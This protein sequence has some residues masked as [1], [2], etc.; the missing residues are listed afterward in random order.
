MSP[1]ILSDHSKNHNH[2][3]VFVYASYK[4][5]LLPSTLR[6]LRHRSS[7]D[8]ILK[9]FLDSAYQALR[10]EALV[11]A[12][13]TGNN[14]VALP[15]TFQELADA[16][17]VTS[18]WPWAIS[19][20]TL[21]Q[22][23]VVLATRADFKDAMRG[24][25]AA[26]W[27][28]E[29][30][31]T[32]EL[33]LTT[34]VTSELELISKA[35]ETIKL[36]AWIDFFLYT[37]HSNSDIVGKQRVIVRVGSDEVPSIEKK[38]REDRTPFHAT[39]CG[40]ATAISDAV[41]LAD[42]RLAGDGDQNHSVVAVERS[43]IPVFSEME[44]G[45]F[46]TKLEQRLKERRIKV[47]ITSEP[48]LHSQPTRAA[49]VH[50]DLGRLL[51]EPD[52]GRSEKHFQGTLELLHD[53]IAGSRIYAP[54]IQVLLLGGAMNDTCAVAAIQA[55]DSLEQPYDPV[56]L[57]HLL[58][59]KDGHRYGDEPVNLSKVQGSPCQQVAI[60]GM[61]CR[62]PGANDAD[63][64]WQLLMEGKSTCEE[65]PDRLYRY[66]DYHA[67]SY[68][69]RNVMRVKTGNFIASSGLFDKGI[70]G[71][72][73]SSEDC[74]KIDPQQRLAILTAHETLQ[75]AGYGFSPFKHPRCPEQWSTHIAYCSDDY[76][77]HLSQNIEADFVSN[78]HRAHLVAKI[79]ENFGFRG[80]ACT[81]DTACSSALVAVEAA[82]N[83]LLAGETSAAL[84]GG[85]N[86]LTQPQITIG[87]DR[88]FF[89]SPSS[90]CMTLD[91]AG[92]GYSRAD[93]VSIMLLK[94]L[95]DAVRDG[96]PILA[97][98]SSAATNHSGESFSITHP[99][100]RTQ[101]RLYQAGMLA[102]GTLPKDF[103]YIEMHGTGTQSG[104]FEEVTGIVQTFAE[105]KRGKE[106]PLVLGSLKANI[107]HSEAASGASSMI[108][109]IQIYAHG[110]VPRH[111]GIRT[112][113]NTKLPPLDGLHVPLQE[114]KLDRSEFAF[115]LVDNFS[116]AGG[117][118]SI[119]MNRGTVY[120]ER[121]SKM[122]IAALEAD[123]AQD[124]ASSTKHHLLFV[125]AATPFSLDAKR[126]RLISFL[127]SNTDVSL[128]EFCST[129][130]LSD[131]MHSFRLIASPSSLAEARAC[132]SSQ[133]SVSVSFDSIVNKKPTIGIAFSGQGAQY[134][135]MAREL[136][137]RSATFRSHVDHCNTIA[138]SLQLPNLVEVIHPLK[139]P[140]DSSQSKIEQP[141]ERRADGFSPA[142]YQ[143]ALIATE[144]GLASMLRGWGLWPACVV[145]HSLGEYAALWMSGIISLLSL[146]ELVGRRAML[147]MELCEPNASSMLA[148][149]EGP[150]RVRQLL[151]LPGYE[152]L[153]IACLNSPNDTVVAGGT[154]EIESLLQLCEQ[155]KPKVKAMAIPVPYA[156]HSRAVE[157][158]MK[159]FAMVADCHPF[160]RPNISVASNV[161]GR[162]PNS[163]SDSFNAAYLVRHLRQ[164]V[165]FAESILDL[166]SQ[167]RVDTWIEI[168]P[169]P[170]CIPMLKGCYADSGQT[171]AFVA[172]FRKGSSS[173]TCTLNLVKEL[174]SC[175]IE[176][177]WSHVFEDL[178]LRFCHLGL[179][180][181][182]PLYP[183]DLEEYW[184]PFKD[185]CL[186]DHLMMTQ[187]DQGCAPARSANAASD[188]HK[189]VVAVQRWP[190]PSYAL[191]WQCVKLDGKSPSAMFLARVN[192]RPFRDFIQG[193][194]ILGIPLAPAT[195]FIE[196]AQEAGMYWWRTDPCGIK[197][198]NQQ[199]DDV[200]IEVLDLSMV[201][202]LY[203]N[204][205]DPKQ[206]IEVSLQGNPASTDGSIVQFFS[207]N[208]NQ[209][210]KH[211]YGS[212]RVRIIT[213]AQVTRD[214]AKISH[215]IMTTASTVKANAASVI[216]TDTVYKNFEAIV[217]YLD[218]FRG[219]KTVW[220]TEDGYEAV[221][222]VSF[223]ANAVNGR[224][225]CSPML[226]DSLGGLTGFISNVGFAEGPF[227]FMAEAIGRVVTM[228]GL[229][230]LQPGSD[231]KVHVYARM[232]RDKELSKGSA[233]FFLPDGELM[234]MMAS[235]I[236]KRIR[237][238]ML[239]RLVQISSKAFASEAAEAARERD[240]KVNRT[241]DTKS[242]Q[243]TSERRVQCQ[244]KNGLLKEAKASAAPLHGVTA[245]CEPHCDSPMDVLT[246]PNKRFSCSAPLHICGPQL[247]Q[248]DGQN[249][250]F[251]FP[252]GSGTASIYPKVEST[253]SV[254][255]YGFH[256]PYLGQIEA[257]SR[258]IA[259]LVDRYVE[260]LHEV[261]PRGPY[262]LAG[263]S[264]GGVFA[265]EVARRLLS[266]GHEVNYLGLIDSPNPAQIRPLPSNTLDEILKKITS[267]T[268]REHFKSCAL[269]LPEYRCSAFQATDRKPRTVF[270]ANA[271]GNSKLKGVMANEREW[272]C[273][274]STTA[275]LELHEV[276]GD[277]WTCLE[278]AL[279]LV[280]NS[281]ARVKP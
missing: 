37:G 57:L 65:I 14:Q 242:Q 120:R 127:D 29:S 270:I 238:D 20:T 85:V 212:C 108:K 215:L 218:G 184:V 100:G 116:A 267:N 156:F 21:V 266:V 259:E 154:A 149:R 237:R 163:E 39:L 61:S 96:D 277:H 246:N 19:L 191:L 24:N 99:H 97:V 46:R 110:E 111:I 136:Y 216:R 199:E 113:L 50:V 80:E 134:L 128:T 81:Y 62:L 124:L 165:Q 18:A 144:V 224:F 13:I 185:R 49:D 169:H 181:R 189:G 157:P 141:H 59:P 269:S 214:W 133:E 117:N 208:A 226:L 76:R 75:K 167:I 27:D 229:R 25:F 41:N 278:S 78:T 151:E 90:Q 87:L 211:Q 201:A 102:S 146:I 73:V 179:A 34:R 153:E 203:L 106:S 94:R 54:R 196:L 221:S 255:V 162:V 135:D 60:I 207:H 228:P 77:E 220:M 145:G 51:L 98:I 147:M 231:T 72:A 262:M 26:I 217:L 35:V 150:E 265:L 130:S 38:C 219:M 275:N 210:Q 84:T 260:M 173:W 17:L 48:P 91:D 273:F 249:V 187:G 158:L 31:L 138:L 175:G 280:V 254:S 3:V 253:G 264:I 6:L 190:K 281:A 83:S 119:V 174:A 188:A 194:I 1:G 223:N 71:E 15:H 68:R 112:K 74:A 4:Q 95:Q 107:G 5:I 172:S 22:V 271:T 244:S 122:S 235:I 180:P 11:A 205:Q 182:L 241:D 129:V 43:L 245:T 200:I 33:L 234:G 274:W 276:N 67:A 258:G 125:T 227:V 69:E 16:D 279:H 82:C 52:V 86:I 121:L 118:S 168:G 36:A 195:V 171:P 272:R 92:A 148:I 159:R 198:P 164:P 32:V 10:N 114:I 89:L 263:W 7:Y 166:Q 233:Y 186:R 142:Q 247:K 257:W 239:T 12:Q 225:M 115:T 176:L 197:S 126:R 63:E 232:E 55:F 240:N 204:E 161:F 213:Q 8:V 192:Q 206:S 143:L 193:H 251:L 103:T 160:S 56:K 183:F 209:H 131:A 261:Q 44:W 64:L 40:Y 152:K 45:E 139:S 177:N 256:S 109:T 243:C 79:N 178:G 28:P 137:E 58:Y 250:L 170:T 202:S 248:F 104:D 140:Q 70:L 42:L 30:F 268:I 236:F 53:C 123:S 88:G 155:S 23:A 222:E 9:A 93:A 47:K 105:G 230:K 66:Q 101:K 252:D 2:K 132:L